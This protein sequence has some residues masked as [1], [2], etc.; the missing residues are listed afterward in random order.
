M[1][2]VEFAVELPLFSGP[3]RLLAELILDQ[4]MDVCDVRVARVTDRFLAEGLERADG[5]PLEEA[6]AFV[7]MC[8]VLLELKVGRLLPRPGSP[9]EEDLVGGAA[10]DLVYARSLELA[11]FRQVAGKL[12]ERMAAAS[13]MAPRTA[14]PPPELAH[15]Y[16]DVLEKVTPDMLAAVARKV[17]SPPKDLDLSHVTPI[18]FSLAEAL[19]VVRERLSTWRAVRFRDLIDGCEERIE[20][21]V[22]FLALLELH[23]EGEVELSQASV[24]GDIEVRWQ[25]SGRGGG[26]NGERRGSHRSQPLSEGDTR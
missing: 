18:K 17:L 10:P 19:E 8:A 16:P 23:R 9:S 6:T 24:F 25:G 14:G 11:A 12:A 4:R 13:L 15:L 5:W 7:A 21:V 3:F 22:R 1:S 2:S 20:V 26:S